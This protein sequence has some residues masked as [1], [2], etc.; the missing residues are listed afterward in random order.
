MDMS[1]RTRC[2]LVAFAVLALGLMLVPAA[3]ADIVGTPAGFGTKN[4]G[5][6]GLKNGDGWTENKNNVGNPPL[7]SGASAQVTDDVSDEH[8]TVFYLSPQV[9]TG[10]WIATF[11]YQ[12]SGTKLADG[13]A[14]VI[15]N[16]PLGANA[17]TAQDG[18]SALGYQGI[19]NSVAVAFNV[20]SQSNPLHPGTG[21]VGE[22]DVLFLSNSLGVT[23]PPGGTYANDPTKTATIPFSISS[24][25]PI[26][27]SLTFDPISATLTETL[28]DTATGGTDTYTYNIDISLIVGADSRNLITSTPGTAFVGFT[29]GTGGSHA[30]QTFSNFTFIENP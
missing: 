23:M 28:T 7:I 6:G 24:G 2:L 9:V 13:A 12:V 22:T 17:G 26:Q 18:G 27:V 1:R 10:P 21:H 20:Y 25:D 19:D 15:H 16:D 30:I 29:G 11:T 5:L 4:S 3:L 14:F 8:N